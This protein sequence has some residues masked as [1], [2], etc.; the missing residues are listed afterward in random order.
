MLDSRP[1]DRPRVRWFLV[2]Q[3]L[4]WLGTAIA[5]AVNEI[6]AWLP[7]QTGD[8][9]IVP[10]IYIVM[11]VGGSLWVV[12]QYRRQGID[13]HRIVGPWPQ[14]VPWRFL[15]GLL[16]VLFV[17]SIGAF[18]VS[19]TLVSIWFPQHVE[20][21]LQ[22]TIFIGAGESAFP[23]VYNLLMVGVLT[24][25]APVFEEFLF[26]GFL[27]HRWG[28]CWSIPTA[29]LV[30]SVL[31]GVL[32]SNIVGLSVFGLVMALLYLRNHN[33]GLTI[34]IHSLNNALAAGLEI[35]TSGVGSAPSPSLEAFQ[36]NLWLGVVFLVV[37]T[38]FLV[39]FVRQNWQVTRAP[40]P[41]FV[42]GDRSAVE[43]APFSGE[44]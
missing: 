3:V 37:S 28:T 34:L 15:I 11:F 14:P 21:I 19:F 42:N 32:H 9:M 41:Y 22:N 39:H 40:L 30:S 17:F 29:V 18:Q 8:P 13:W 20:S 25:F 31:F 7:L 27:I 1:F 36:A 23:W 44:N 38:P 12:W 4:L 2:L 5:L 6:I 43:I 26:R 16:A 35:V 24:V 10:L 33:L